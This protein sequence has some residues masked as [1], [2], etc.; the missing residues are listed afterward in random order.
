MIWNRFGKVTLNHNSIINDLPSRNL[1]GHFIAWK[2]NK[3]II[4]QE[5]SWAV[6]LMFHIT[7]EMF[8]NLRVTGKMS[9]YD[10]ITGNLTFLEYETL[11]SFKNL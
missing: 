7:S 4:I 11:S 5:Y 10:C 6:N 9:L 2:S 3:L 1:D 8:Q